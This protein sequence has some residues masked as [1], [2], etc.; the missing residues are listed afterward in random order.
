MPDTVPAISDSASAMLP[1]VATFGKG[2]SA[3]PVFERNEATKQKT[4]GQSQTIDGKVTWRVDP[5]DA[6]EVPTIGRGCAGA[7][8]GTRPGQGL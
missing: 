4:S 1:S 6:R 5:T 8:I 7:I 3:R 2:S